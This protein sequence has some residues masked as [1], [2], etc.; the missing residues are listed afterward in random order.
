MPSITNAETPKDRL[1]A[2]GREGIVRASRWQ[3]TA[4]SRVDDRVASG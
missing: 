1:R 3:E 4:G 2:V